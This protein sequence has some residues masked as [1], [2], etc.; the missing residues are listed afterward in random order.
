MRM[1]LEDLPPTELRS[2]PSSFY[3][4]LVYVYR[5]HSP[6]QCNE[7]E[8]VILRTNGSKWTSFYP[9]KRTLLPSCNLIIPGVHQ[10]FHWLAPFYS[11]DGRICAQCIN[12]GVYVLGN[13]IV[14]TSFT[15]SHNS[16]SLTRRWL[17]NFFITSQRSHW[18][19]NFLFFAD[20]TRN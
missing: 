7:T 11:L 2:L 4:R 18:K 17:W 9:L 13:G 19:K 8:L 20:E 1:T 14:F 5:P 16:P 10:P 12:L 6:S 3:R 15:R